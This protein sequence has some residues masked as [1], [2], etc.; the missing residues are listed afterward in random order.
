MPI[1]LCV[2]LGYTGVFASATNTLLAP[3]MIGLEVFGGHQ[4]IAF[5]ICIFA[6]LVNGNKS[7]YTA[8]I[9]NF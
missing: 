9:K 8:Q 5:I 3:M 6:Y 4:M 2:A 1:E 7:I